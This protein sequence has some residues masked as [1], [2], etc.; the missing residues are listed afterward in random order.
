MV[1]CDFIFV[2]YLMT[3]R[4][5]RFSSPLPLGER[6]REREH[7]L[8]SLNFSNPTPSGVARQLVTFLVLPRKVTKRGRPQRA[9]PSGFPAL[10]GQ[11]GLL[12][13]SHDPLRGHVLRHIRRTSPCCPA[14]L[15]GAQGKEKRKFKITVWTLRAHTV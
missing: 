4:P 9:A 14:L 12:I 13:N 3:V 10:L 11:P 6:V 7:S 1:F 8:L 5:K 15:G 2:D